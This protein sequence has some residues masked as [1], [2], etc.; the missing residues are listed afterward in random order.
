MNWNEIFTEIIIGISGIVISSL[1]IIV[2]FLIN[3]WVKNQ[4]VKTIIESLNEVVRNSVLETYQTYVEEM[5]AK[6]IFDTEAQKIAL[7]HALQQIRANMPDK[8]KSW[9][10]ANIQDI[11]KYLRQLIEAQIGALKNSGGKNG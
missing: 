4:E 3:K 2:T 11:N 8:V 6:G 7:E 9:L 1:G 10:E 5:K